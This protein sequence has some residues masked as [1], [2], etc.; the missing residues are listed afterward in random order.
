MPR[1]LAKLEPSA[2]TPLRTELDGLPASR[3][4]WSREEIHALEL[5]HA[6][7][8]PLLVRGDP[9][10]GK[11]QLARAVATVLGWRLHAVTIHPRFEAQD[12]ICRFD[13]MRRLADAQRA[14]AMGAAAG[15]G[16]ESLPPDTDYCHPG[17]LWLALAWNDALRCKPMSAER[18]QPTPAGHV[19]LIDE[20]DKADS[21]LPN[22]LL[23]VLGQ[24]TLAIEPLG[25]RV[26][27][28]TEGNPPLIVI[29]TNEERELPAAFLRRCAVLNLAPEAGNYRGWLIERAKAHFGEQGLARLDE[30]VI[31][32]AA[33]QLMADRELIAPS[34]QALPGPAEFLDLL[35]ALDA[36]APGDTA[37]Q[38]G[39]LAELS[40]YAFVKHAA[41]PAHP[42]LTQR[43]A[44]IQP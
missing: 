39:W 2:I 22:S 29:T 33:D 8:R 31:A 36:M 3:H 4:R 16:T 21:D 30:A 13:A 32:E 23:E 24:R 14:G 34:G 19:V 12:L 35:R 10:T 1:L 38:R 41:D 11:T 40:R 28:A 18:N 43:R 27:A 26:A 17:P 15:R 44:P 9:G 5:A 20:I 42:A 25:E 7:G 37:V 6:A